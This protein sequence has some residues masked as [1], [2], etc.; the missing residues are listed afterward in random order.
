[1]RSTCVHDKPIRNNPSPCLS[2][3]FHWPAWLAMLDDLFCPEQFAYSLL[4]VDLGL[5]C[6]QVMVELIVRRCVCSLQ[7]R[8]NC[9]LRVCF[10]FDYLVFFPR[11]GSLFWFNH[12]SAV[13]VRTSSRFFF[14]CCRVFKRR[15]MQRAFA[16]PIGLTANL[17]ARV[18]FFLVWSINAVRG[19]C[20]SLVRLFSSSSNVELLLVF[21]SNRVVIFRF[22]RSCSHS[23]VIPHS[24][25]FIVF[26]L[27][28]L[29]CLFTN[30]LPFS[31]SLQWCDWNLLTIEFTVASTI[32]QQRHS[33]VSLETFARHLQ[34]ID[35]FIDFSP[36]H[37]SALLLLT[38]FE[39]SK[40][41]LQSSRFRPQFDFF[42]LYIL[43]CE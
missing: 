40:F 6:R 20:S 21:V 27:L 9:W 19:R 14:C 43:N 13:A 10:L 15:R 42:S 16:A 37:A 33:S 28:S 17:R 36:T 18:F 1:M 11:C 29:K 7:K 31:S 35:F 12:T 25:V 4:T 3:D 22:V 30:V 23:D 34:K 39:R 26:F 32:W 8:T 2:I 38:C 41:R 24:R 5:N